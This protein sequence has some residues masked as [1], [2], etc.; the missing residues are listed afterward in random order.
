MTK[1]ILVLISLLITSIS[2][3]SEVVL[4][5]TVFEV[6]SI[7]NNDGSQSDQWQTPDKLLPGERVGY[8]IKV[9]NQG[10]EPAADI[11]IANPIPEHTQY[12]NGSAKGLDT[13]IEFS[14]DDGKTFALPAQLTV[15]KEGK[16]VQATAADFTQV[17]WTFNKPLAAGSSSTVQYIVKIK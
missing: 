17:R 8:Q 16:R 10:S 12:I 2:A 5:N 3:F 13:Q 9:E 11:I 15:E 6:V 1:K 14:V 7:K 4:S